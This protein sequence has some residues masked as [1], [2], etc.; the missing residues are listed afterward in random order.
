M[1]ARLLQCKVLSSEQHARDQAPHLKNGPAPPGCC[2]PREIPIS[3]KTAPVAF[4]ETVDALKRRIE[5]APVLEE[6]QTQCF[7][8][9][10][11][12]F[13]GQKMDVLLN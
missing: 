5:T 9:T 8:I 13:V 6:F 4:A 12:A 2:L 3:L 7:P 10:D 1:C 11:D